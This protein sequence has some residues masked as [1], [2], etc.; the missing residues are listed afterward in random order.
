M[1]P[2]TGDVRR[3]QAL[4][5]QDRVVEVRCG[6]QTPGLALDGHP[7]L[8]I[9]TIAEDLLAPALYPEGHP[10]SWPVIGSM[11]DLDGAQRAIY[12][13]FAAGDGA[14]RIDL[15]TAIDGEGRRQPRR[16][17]FDEVFG[18]VRAGKAARVAAPT[19]LA[20]DVAAGLRLAA[21]NPAALADPAHEAAAVA[22]AGARGPALEALAAIADE[23]RREAVGD[24]VTYVVNRNINFTNV[25]YTGCRFCAFA[26]R[27]G[28]PDAFTLPLPEVGRRVDEAVAAGATEICM[29]GTRSSSRSKTS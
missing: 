11:A 3:L 29:Q 4:E 17:D 7:K 1:E 26:Q 8:L 21:D 27:E 14:G 6:R 10:Y 13:S 25:C 22:L 18:G 20:A 28:D 16:S 12:A 15:A 23:L 5:R 24:D 9:E 2:L 19:R